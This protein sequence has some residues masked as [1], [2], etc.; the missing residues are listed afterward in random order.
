M[1]N[2]LKK[3]ADSMFIGYTDTTIVLPPVAIMQR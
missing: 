2:Q 3:N 1:K